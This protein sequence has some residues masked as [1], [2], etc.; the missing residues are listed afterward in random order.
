ME[1]GSCAQAASL[2]FD[3]RPRPGLPLPV[4]CRLP[5]QVH[6]TFKLKYLSCSQVCPLWGGGE[7]AG[8]G[9]EGQ[10]RELL[11]FA[12]FSRTGVVWW[13]LSLREVWATSAGNPAV[14]PAECPRLG[15]VWAP[16][17]RASTCP[18]FPCRLPSGSLLIS[19]SFWVSRFPFIS[20]LPP[21]PPAGTH[22]PFQKSS[23]CSLPSLGP[24]SALTSEVPRSLPWL[25]VISGLA[26]TCASTDVIGHN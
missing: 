2:P 26:C 10:G 11:Y 1:P 21:P 9:K 20:V 15:G 22:D 19:S 23:P 17:G 14:T 8:D 7:V 4:F 25:S 5:T 24:L 6:S 13:A 18:P 16:P 12:A 3:V